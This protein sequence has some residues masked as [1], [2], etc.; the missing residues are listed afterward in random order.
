MQLLFLYSNFPA[1]HSFY[2]S[3][4]FWPPSPEK[5]MLRLKRIFLSTKTDNN[6]SVGKEPKVVVTPSISIFISRHGCFEAMGRYIKLTSQMVFSQPLPTIYE[7]WWN[8]LGE[9]LQNLQYF[10]TWFFIQKKISKI[11]MFICTVESWL[12]VCKLFLEG[13]FTFLVRWSF[14]FF[15]TVALL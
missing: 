9:M 4:L 15:S 2:S 7:A 10:G 1:N 12:K 11:S 3:P 6:L 13:A 5:K 8:D 14:Y